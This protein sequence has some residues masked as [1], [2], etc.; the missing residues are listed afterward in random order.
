MIQVETSIVIR[1]PLETVFAYVSDPGHAGAWQLAW[2]RIPAPSGSPPLTGGEPGTSSQPGCL[3]AESLAEISLPEPNRRLGV[4]VRSG[5]V[6]C[7]AVYHFDPV[8]E[9]TCITWTGRVTASGPFQLVEALAGQTVVSEVES[10]LVM[11]KNV[12]E[13]ETADSSRAV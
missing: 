7:D 5:P 2:T 3:P 13:A 12:L 10:S 1:R 11:L 8:P 9:G 4:R 6:E